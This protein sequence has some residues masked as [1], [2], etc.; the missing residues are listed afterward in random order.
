VRSA[1]VVAFR[2]RVPSVKRS[3]HIV[4]NKCEN[5]VSFKTNVI[6]LLVQCWLERGEVLAWQGT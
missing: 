3:N 4:R 1:L 5:N 6:L 2:V